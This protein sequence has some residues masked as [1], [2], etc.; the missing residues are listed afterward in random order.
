MQAAVLGQTEEDQALRFY[1]IV[2]VRFPESV[3]VLSRPHI[4]SR[5]ASFPQSGCSDTIRTL[6]QPQEPSCPARLGPPLL[7]RAVPISEAGLQGEQP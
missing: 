3:L 1:L 2:T 5:N 7:C 4:V 6:Y